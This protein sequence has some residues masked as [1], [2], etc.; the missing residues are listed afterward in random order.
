MQSWRS[1]RQRTP[2]YRASDS[3]ADLSELGAEVVGEP[4]D[5]LKAMSKERRIA[6]YSGQRCP[7]PRGECV[8]RAAGRVQRTGNRIDQVIEEESAEVTGNEK[9][10]RKRAH[11]P[12]SRLSVAVG[13][14][15]ETP[16]LPADRQH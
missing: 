16:Q 1:L 14:L 15:A 13:R 10:P 3:Q 6:E 7:P 4:A 8:S 11:H 5:D 9:G 2:P 12:D